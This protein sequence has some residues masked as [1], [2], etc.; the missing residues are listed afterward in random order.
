MRIIIAIIYIKI[1]WR[2]VIS[3][4]KTIKDTI[5]ASQALKE[6]MFNI[7][8]QLFLA[9]KNYMTMYTMIYRKKF[10]SNNNFNNNVINIKKF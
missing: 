7:I 10:Q 2:K 6:G 9:N 3:R 5:N 8:E 4:Q 1:S